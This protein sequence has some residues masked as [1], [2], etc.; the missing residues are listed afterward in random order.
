VLFG[1]A[2]P[3]LGAGERRFFA[4]SDPAGFILFRRNCEDPA[5]LSA[6]VAALRESV[7]RAAPVMIDQEGGRVQRLRPPHWPSLPAAGRIGAIADDA[8]AEAAAR[9]QG[10]VL[11]TIAG[12]AGIDV[13]AAPVLDLDWPGADRTVVGDRSF[14]AAPARV[15]RLGRALAEGLMASGALPVMKHMPGHGR[16]RVDSHAALPVIDAAPAELEATDFAPFRLLADLPA[17]M[18]GHLVFTAIDSARPAT[19]SPT[20]IGQVIRGS[21]GF[22][23]LLFSDDLSMGALSGPIE[24]RAAASLAAGCDIALHCNGKLREMRR[25]ADAVPRMTEDAVARLEGARAAVAAARREL[26]P[27]EV[28]LAAL[29]T[30]V[31]AA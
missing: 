15:A 8:A 2:G 14:G 20:V 13:V 25:I 29:E 26:P 21:I 6:L 17:G 24:G 18:T 22:R 27:V 7:G 16:S 9:A 28:L 1:C 4:E 31:T 5:Q 30:T 23:G 3:R 19:L 11:G 12:D 10:M